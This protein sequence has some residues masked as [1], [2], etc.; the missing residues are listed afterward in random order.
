LRLGVSEEE[1]NEGRAHHPDG[2]RDNAKH[3]GL[4]WNGNE[5]QHCAQSD[6]QAQPGDH[7]QPI[8]QR[9]A[10]VLLLNGSEVLIWN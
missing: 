6:C 10:S 4:Y 3:P 1:E 9:S 7:F 8:D 2:C 5:P